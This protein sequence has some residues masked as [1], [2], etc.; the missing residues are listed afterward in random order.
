[1]DAPQPA[2]AQSYQIFVKKLDSGTQTVRVFRTWTVD[3]LVQEIVRLT[4]T[5]ANRFR[6]TFGGKYLQDRAITLAELNIVEESTLLMQVLTDSTPARDEGVEPLLAHR[7]R[8]LG[9][10]AEEAGPGKPIF[11]LICI[12][13]Y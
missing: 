7:L 6:L 5:P 8:Q 11:V 3:E 10:E 1:M 4:G 2:A 13:C 9:E 12:G